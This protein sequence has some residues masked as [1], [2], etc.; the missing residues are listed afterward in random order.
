MGIGK[1]E[2]DF[3][4]YRLY[5]FTDYI[6]DRQLYASYSYLSNHLRYLGERIQIFREAQG[7]FGFFLY[8]DSNIR[9]LCGD[10][11]EYSSM[12]V[13]DIQYHFFFYI[14]YRF[15]LPDPIPLFQARW[16]I[17]QYRDFGNLYLFLSIGL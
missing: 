7:D 13:I 9:K 14:M 8:G 4:L 3:R 11:V 12:N 5:D 15:H 1:W 10:A 16:R 2:L 6:Y 17:F